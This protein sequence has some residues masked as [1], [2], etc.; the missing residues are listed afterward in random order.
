[1][2]SPIAHFACVLLG[3]ALNWAPQL[4]V[5]GG[6]ELGPMGSAKSAHAVYTVGCIVFSSKPAKAQQKFIT[7]ETGRVLK[8]TTV[9]SG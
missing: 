6:P 5:L 9:F 7:D 4:G 2:P 3:Q 8:K 1:M